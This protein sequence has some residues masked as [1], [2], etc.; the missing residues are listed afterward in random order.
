MSSSSSPSSINARNEGIWGDDGGDQGEEEGEEEEGE[1][2]ER[3]EAI[4]SD[5]TTKNEVT[6]TSW[7]GCVRGGKNAEAAEKSAVML[8]FFFS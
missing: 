2:E 4:G 5:R 3:I 8:L 1:E 7:W 6:S